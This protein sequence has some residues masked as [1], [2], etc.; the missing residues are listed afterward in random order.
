MNRTGIEDILPL[1]PLQEGLL[2]HALFDDQGADVYNVQTALGLERIDPAGLREAARRLVARQPSLRAC[3]RQVDSG[4]TL[5][6]IPRTVEPPWRE[7][8]LSHLSGAA[9]EREAAR[10]LDADRLR[11]F[12]MAAP[13]LLRFLLIKL[14]ADRFRLALTNHHILLDGWSMPL[15][16]GELLALYRDTEPPPPVPY[17]DYL[18][19]LAARDR[20][21]AESAW[22]EALAGLDEPTLLAPSGAVSASRAQVVVDLGEDLS[23]AL[24]EAARERDLTLNNVMQG[25]W[26]LLLSRLTG[27]DD[28][29]FGTTVSGRPPELPGVERMIGL[30]INTVPV[31]VRMVP[32]ESL[33]GL[34]RRQRDEQARLIDQQFLG[35]RDIQRLAGLGE[36][37]DTLYVFENY[38]VAAAPEAAD[39]AIT[40]ASGRDGGHY[41][42][43]LAIVP[44]DR[45]R[46]RIDFARGV[47]DRDAVESMLAR[48]RG[49]AESFVAEPTRPVQSVDVLTAAERD[50][51][52][53]E[54]NRTAR[55][56][57]ATTLP[58]L[59]AAQ[60]AVSPDA[61]AVVCEGVE[62]TYR[63]LDERAN[64]LARL[65]I[66]RGVGPERVV[67]VAIA[68]SVELVVALHAVVRA[69]A[70]YLPVDVDYPA[71]RVEFMLRDAEPA[72]LLTTAGQAVVGEVER[73]LV[74]EVDT[75]LLSSG[76]VVDG[77]RTRRL[78]PG[79]P[80]YVIYTSGSTGV[81]KGV[82][83]SQSGVVNRLL[84]MQDAYGL[85]SDDR[86]LQK[87]SASFDV[88]VW[89]F[90]WPHIAGA[91]LVVA[92][93]GGHRD[94]GYLAGLI[95]EASVTTAHFVPSMLAAFLTEPLAGGCLSLRLV[96]CSGEALA[97]GTVRDFARVLPAELHNLYGPTEASIDVTSWIC[98]SETDRVAIG[99]PIA[100]TRVYVLDGGMRLVPPGVVGELY[101][102]GAGLARGYL[103]RPGLSASRFV[104][105]PFQAGER[106]YRTGDLVRWDADGELVFVGRVDD[107]V[108][109]RGFRVEPGE[110]ETVLA[111][112]GAVAQVAVVVRDG[113]LVAYVVAASADLDLAALRGFVAARL[114]EYMVPAAFMVL[115]ALPLTPNGKLDRAALPAPEVRVSGRAPRDAREEVFCGLF[116]DVLG[117]DRVGIDDNFFELGGDS[118]S[119][120]QLVNRARKAGLVIT[121]RLVFENPTV[122]GLALVARGAD[123]A[124]AAEEDGTGPVEP[125][126]IMRRLME[127]GTPR[128]FAQSM[129]VRVPA[130]SDVTA[131]LQ[132][133]LDHHDALRIRLLD[134]ALTIGAPG[135]VAAGS[136]VT[137]VDATG[138]ADDEVRPVLIAA[139]R[140][141]HAELDP[142]SGAV[143]R[144]VWADA[145]PHRDGW[146]LLLVHHLA[147]DAVSWRILVPD[148]LDAWAAL[149]R[150]RP[151][152]L[153]PV[154]TS[155]RRWAALL[156]EE[157]PR[158]TGEMDLWT[159]ML[160]VP[161]PLWPGL[162]GR[163]PDGPAGNVRIEVPPELA[164][165]LLATVP[166]I[167]HAGVDEVLLS[168]LVSAVAEWRRRGNGNDTG[169]GAVLVDV[170]RHGREE[171]T[172]GVDL[173]RTVGWFTSLF[174][175]RLAAD[176]DPGR[177]LK[178][179]KERLRTLP[180]NGIG[181]GLLRH[182]NPD[183]APLLAEQPVP[184]IGF[185]YLGRVDGPDLDGSEQRAALSHALDINVMTLPGPRLVAHWTFPEPAVPAD[186]VRELAQGWRDALAALV[187]RAAE[188]D[189]GGH[190]PSDFPLIALDQ[191]EIEDLEDLFDGGRA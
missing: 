124:A 155:F 184:Q 98:P 148:L 66:G 110:I 176:T 73:V 12:D 85:G 18:A 88:S 180:D 92:R 104:A 5:Q 159:S 137:R 59:L 97:A 42:V 115:D 170:E 47:V 90:F 161:G 175:V 4:A 154:G 34:L 179:V 102:G 122:A 118:I 54:W 77:E 17:R 108:K 149:A 67:A 121:A 23:S 119:S 74:D 153:A 168:G 10:L 39:V 160:A 11:R 15:L 76:R 31:R 84:W 186:D 51:L 9:Q 187:A 83:I 14:G 89:E 94:P 21:A 78:L 43:M 62:L 166:A 126:P 113:R 105:D 151:P 86:V 181:Y 79:H 190:S 178:Q 146:L 128:G 30:L 57:P 103:N 25:L 169:A 24:A 191:D 72:L 138:L 93:P 171:F 19:W 2:F 116:A 144:A 141:A 177:T 112:H 158:R 152:E 95:R 162:D 37:F 139:G 50:R 63:E 183:T 55:H 35:L 82:V 91:G 106:L 32:G 96:I 65:L 114:P 188:P 145:G 20:P 16:L 68:R 131:G 46:L 165:P 167:F 27:R 29:V 107:Q 164:E 1:S 69:G 8:D 142:R 173:S 41:P 120:I 81:P 134:D 70:A 100:N 58:D 174:P 44:G 6:M 75:S 56:V 71:E 53:V 143:V 28:V 33:T 36:L 3:F 117:L 130:G 156:A 38:P 64:R 26:G 140:R 60:A 80:A 109:V 48:L 125:T 132:A 189:A 182:L 157:A 111:R 163:P 87:T 99:R 45:I 52:L 135:T 101:L 172:R 40:D 133:V 147:V 129:L 49:L 185:N 22:R 150:G 7:V 61:V 136:S 13:P 127:R 123:D